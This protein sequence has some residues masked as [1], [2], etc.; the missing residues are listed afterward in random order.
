MRS[1]HFDVQGGGGGGSLYGHGLKSVG[2]F[3]YYSILNRP[4]LL[5][6]IKVL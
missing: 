1:T 3:L 6:G 2:G 4:E 5:R